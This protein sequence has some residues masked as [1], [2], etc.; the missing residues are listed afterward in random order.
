MG[1]ADQGQD[2]LTTLC[3][4]LPCDNVHFDL[5]LVCCSHSGSK[6]LSLLSFCD[7]FTMP[8]YCDCKR[9]GCVA[10]KHRGNASC[11]AR[12]DAAGDSCQCCTKQMWHHSLCKRLPFGMPGIPAALV[13]AM[14]IQEPMPSAGPSAGP[15]QGPACKRLRLALKRPGLVVHHLWI[16]MDIEAQGGKLG[17]SNMANQCLMSWVPCEQWLWVYRPCL[18]NDR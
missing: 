15:T 3:T 9:P 7:P 18:A 8:S 13:Q 12:V 4:D 6:Q 1:H 14:D 2:C 17:L 5:P 11:E 16:N 10:M